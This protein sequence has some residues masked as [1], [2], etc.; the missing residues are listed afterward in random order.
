MENYPPLGVISHPRQKSGSGSHYPVISWYPAAPCAIL[1]LELVGLPVSCAY[2]HRGGGVTQNMHFQN[3][4]CR[5]LQ[6]FVG[7][8]LNCQLVL[9][10]LLFSDRTH[11]YAASDRI[12]RPQS[13]PRNPCLVSVF[14]SPA[15]APP[16]PPGSPPRPAAAAARLARRLFSPAQ[17]TSKEFLAALTCLL[18]VFQIFTRIPAYR[19]PAA[20]AAPWPVTTLRRT[21]GEGS[22]KRVMPQ[23]DELPDACRFSL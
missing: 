23:R 19:A 4:V 3:C 14:P 2:S 20:P 1:S 12:F 5:D 16:P 15:T 18:D 22:R 9:I 11:C 10:Y 13:R 21:D 7:I 8:V 6:H 17:L